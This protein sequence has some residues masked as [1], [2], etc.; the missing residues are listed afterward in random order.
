MG[1]LLGMDHDVSLSALVRT[2]LV[3]ALVFAGC[4]EP[5]SGAQRFVSNCPPVDTNASFFGQPVGERE[6][7]PPSIVRRAVHAAGEPNMSCGAA[8]S[9]FRLVF[10]PAGRS[11]FV[12]TVWREDRWWASTVGLEYVGSL[13]YKPMPRRVVPV[14][15]DDAK[16]LAS[17]LV[18]AG[19]G[20]FARLPER[21]MDD[22]TV[23]AIER[24]RDRKYEFA[25]RHGEQDGP[26]LRT[27]YM[28]FELAGLPYP[29]GPL[30]WER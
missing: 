10:V 18:R 27:A 3:G 21:A 7:G 29:E 4:A 17:G 24:L 20:S 1:S 23:I 14:S 13:A 5:R 19:F 9:A 30:P 12:I 2:L 15:D 6:F 25:I 22:G 8:T 28:F 16:A 26:F 11:A